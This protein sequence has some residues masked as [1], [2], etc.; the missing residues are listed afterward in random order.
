[1]LIFKI[2]LSFFYLSMATKTLW[3]HACFHKESNLG[4]NNLCLLSIQVH[5]LHQTWTTLPWKPRTNFAQSN[6]T[7]LKMFIQLISLLSLLCNLKV[8]H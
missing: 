6:F 2:F 8:L 7:T 1:V 5:I 4:S 3:Q